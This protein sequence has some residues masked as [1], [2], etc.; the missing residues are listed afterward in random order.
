MMQTQFISSSFN[1]LNFASDIFAQTRQIHF[2]HRS[3]C[4]ILSI[5]SEHVSHNSCVSLIEFFG[6]VDV[7]LCDEGLDLLFPSLGP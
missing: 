4:S 6:F 1:K 5:C 3:H 7:E 2:A